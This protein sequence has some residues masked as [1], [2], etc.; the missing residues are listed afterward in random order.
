MCARLDVESVHDSKKTREQVFRSKR[1]ATLSALLVQIRKFVNP[2]TMK[3]LLPA[4]KVSTGSE[5]AEL[6]RF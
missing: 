5:S 1:P 2:D 3:L 6:G 4:L